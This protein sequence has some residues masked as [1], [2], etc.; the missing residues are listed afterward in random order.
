[1][2]VWIVSGLAL[3]LALSA[4]AAVVLGRFL[5]VAET[6]EELVEAQRAQRDSAVPPLVS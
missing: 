5:F 6:E 2:W 4:L 1:M 3:W